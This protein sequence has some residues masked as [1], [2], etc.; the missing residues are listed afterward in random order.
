METLI[1]IALGLG[2]AA[3]SGLRIFV[4]VLALSVAIHSGWVTPAPGFAW[5]GTTPAL[6]ALAVATVLEIGAYY[7]PWLDHLLDT[8]ATP[9]AVAAGILLTATVLTGV[10]PLVRWTLAVIVGG[11]VAGSVQGA[12]TITRG[13]SA[14]TTAGFAN[15]LVA[16]AELGGA[17]LLAVLALL[18]PFLAAGAVLLAIVL[19][20]RALRRRRRATIAASPA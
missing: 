17:L 19:T 13:L 6:I 2:L 7:V 9:T 20:W 4:P 1:S 16:T 15:P 3:A 8:L 11:G 12:T 18:A 14:V 10:D 5:I